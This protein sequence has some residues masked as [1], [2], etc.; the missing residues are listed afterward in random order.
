M[1]PICCFLGLW[2]ASR[3][4]FDL[5]VAGSG[6]NEIAVRKSAQT[7]FTTMLLAAAAYI[8]DRD[9]CRVMIVQPTSGALADFN[10]D[11]LTPTL[12]QSPVL[13]AKIRSQTSRSGIV[14]D[15]GRMAAG[16]H[17]DADHQVRVAD[18][19]AMGAVRQTLLAHAMPWLRRE[20]PL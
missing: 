19:C 10:K 8:I 11:K 6:V 14:P 3:R 5:M 18:R 20:V 1:F 15:V 13:A 16:L 2:R 12:E 9:P 4:L 7:G 17:L